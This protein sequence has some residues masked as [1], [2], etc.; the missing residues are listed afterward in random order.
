MNSKSSAL[1]VK[2]LLS[3]HSWMGLVIGALMYV[4]CLTGSLVVFFEEFERWEQPGIP[5][6]MDYTPQLIEHSVEQ[7]LLRVTESPASLYVVLPT[8]AMPRIHVSDGEFEWFVNPDGSLGDIPRK[9]WT[10]MLQE[11]HIGLHLPQTVGIILVGILGVM[12]C[13]LVVSG[14]FAHPKIVKD[15]FRLR[16]GGS[17]HLAQADLHNRLSVWGAPFYLIIGFTGAFIGLVGVVIATVAA[18][19]FDNNRDD[20]IDIIYGADPVITHASPLRNYAVAMQELKKVAPTATPIYW[21]IQNINTDSQFIEIA[22]T[23]PGRLTY[24][25]IYR[26]HGNGEYIGH[27]GLADGD[28]GRQVAYSVYRL[29]FGHFGGFWVK[30]VYAA[31]GMALTVVSATGIN[32]WLA[33]RTRRSVLNDL[34]VAIVWG[35]PLALALSALLSLLGLVSSQ[36]FFTSLLGCIGLS[37][38]LKDEHKSKGLFITLL[39]ITFLGVAMT[40]MM[41]FGVIGGNVAAIGLNLVMVSGVV[42]LGGLRRV[43]Y[44]VG[45]K[46]G[47]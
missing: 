11:L 35:T 40:H 12:L 45:W 19:S 22:A 27:Q 26:F 2:A 29:H 41:L 5:E 42:G 6:Y 33:K 8:V 36:V 7:F 15:A 1:R 37:V 31:L 3:G 18:L 34:W 13:A 14:V 43:R 21:V 44:K 28:L 25:E 9:G 17:N 10:Y 24:S 23:L 32:I 20:V 46:F 39:A 47:A 38:W 4:V 30:V 16:L